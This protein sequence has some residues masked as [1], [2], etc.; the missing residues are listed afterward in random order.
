MRLILFVAPMLALISCASAAPPVPCAECAE[1]KSKWTKEVD[2][3][4]QSIQ[5]KNAEI[6]LHQLDLA[7]RKVEVELLQKRVSEL[8]KALA[9][10][11]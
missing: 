7:N 2:F 10:K 3:H 1:W 8:E 6:A 9:E 5:I 11:K 4:Y